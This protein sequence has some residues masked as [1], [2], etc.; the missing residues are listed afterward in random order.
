[1]SGNLEAEATFKDNPTVSVV[2]PVYD[3]QESV[4]PLYRK[5]RDAWEALGKSGGMVFVD[6]GTQEGMFGI[7]RGIHEQDCR[8]RVVRFQKN[9]GRAAAIR[10][11][12]EQR[13]T[14]SGLRVPGS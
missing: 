6:D 13:N 2:V 5:I 12:Q 8:V 9:S 11:K 10:Q 3:E 4:L 7:L 1:M 14:G